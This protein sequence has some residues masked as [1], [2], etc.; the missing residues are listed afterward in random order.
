MDVVGFRRL[1]TVSQLTFE[2]LPQ[3]LLQ[4][5]VYLRIRDGIDNVDQIG[6]SITAILLSIILG[7]LHCIVEILFIF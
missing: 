1:R 7:V 2:T 4:A 5:Y 3:I 6:V